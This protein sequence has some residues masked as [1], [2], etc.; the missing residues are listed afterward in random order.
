MTSFETARLNELISERTSKLFLDDQPVAMI[1]KYIGA[2]AAATV[3]VE[4]GG[5][6]LFKVDAVADPNI[7]LPTGGTDGTID[8]SDASAD[9]LGE[10]VDHINAAADWEAVLVDSL[11]ADSSDNK[12]LLLAAASAKVAAGLNINSDTSEALFITAS[13]QNE[14]LPSLEESDGGFLNRAFR[15]RSKNTFA[16]G[17]NTIEITKA[18]GNTEALIWTQAGGA[19]T[20]EDTIDFVDTVGIDGTLGGRLVVR[21]I[22]S[23][24]AT[25]FLEVLGKSFSIEPKVGADLGFS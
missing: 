21:M 1:I 4:A 23:V 9:T 15:I 14:G 10:I 19:T 12:L 2:A 13:I 20:V 18:V 3:E 24:A 7:K 11:R 22:G 8:V 17:T 25:G 5:D 16:S 6:M